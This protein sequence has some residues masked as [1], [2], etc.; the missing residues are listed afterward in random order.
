MTTDERDV[1]MVIPARDAA[2]TIGVCLDAA[3]VVRERPSSRLARIVLVDDGS[4]D[5]TAAEAVRRGIEVVQGTGEGPAAARNLGWRR[6]TTDLLWFVDADCVAAPD[7]LDSLLPALEDP[8]VAGVGGTYGIAPEASLLERMI[9]EEIMVRHSRMPDEVDF[10]ATFNV[11]YRR[12]VLEQLGGFDE[13]YL[14]AQDAEFAFRVI[15]SGHRLRFERRSVVRHFHADRLMRYLR[16]QCAQGRWR[17]ALHLD[18]RGRGGHNSYSSALDHLQ[19]FIPLSAPFAALATVWGSP[20]WVAILPLALLA[21]LQLPMSIAMVVRA[22][23]SM[24]AFVPLGIVRS[25]ARCIGLCRG[26]LDH[27]RGDRLPRSAR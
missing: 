3:L 26:V 13:R 22:G 18:H 20:P 16:V 15:E 17:V 4:R 9:H 24:A 21:V 2:P 7:A 1:T 14:K 23:P 6:S 12:S 10:L 19:P 5:G 8:S 27:L 25:V 11:V